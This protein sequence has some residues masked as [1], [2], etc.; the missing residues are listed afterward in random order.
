MSFDDELSHQA[1]TA[2]NQEKEGLWPLPL[3]DFHRACCHQ[4]LLTYLTSVL[5]ITRQ[6]QVQRRHSCLT[7]LKITRK[8]G[9]TLTVQ[10]RIVSQRLINGLLARQAWVY[11]HLLVS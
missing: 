3:A 5:V 4:T 9:C 1:L 11:A 10:A 8:V 6:A 7:L 2:A